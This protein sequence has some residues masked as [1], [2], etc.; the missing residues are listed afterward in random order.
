MAAILPAVVQGE[1]DATVMLA[2]KA[3]VIRAKL[4]MA[5]NTMPE[6]VINRAV[7]QLELEESL[8]GLKLEY[9]LARADACCLKELPAPRKQ[10]H[11]QRL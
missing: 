3:D 4:E 1:A 8:E 9:L 7:V 2:Q 11:Q 6:D 10:T 5:Q